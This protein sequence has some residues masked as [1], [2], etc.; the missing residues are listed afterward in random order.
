MKKLFVLV[1]TIVFLS[2]SSFATAGNESGPYIGGSL[3][4]S[5]LDV[6][7]NA[8]EEE[9]V[10]F[11]DD[12]MGFKVFA[13]YNFGQIPMFDFAI[14]G[15]YVDFGG[16]ATDDIP[17]LDVDITAYDIF[18][19]ACYNIGPVGIFG[20]VGHVWW[21]MDSSLSDVLNE[22][23]GDMA[24]GLGLKF[25]FSSVAVR[26]EYERFKFDIDNVGSDI[27]LD[28]ISVGLSWTF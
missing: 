25:Q 11:D 5:S 26:A 15:S 3:G 12:D 23:A 21:K 8:I 13:G 7:I 1:L 20:K 10:N 18:G 14:E 22:S 24:Y 4:Y 16:A 9:D 19:V 27:N 17:D 28:F 6:A 2:I